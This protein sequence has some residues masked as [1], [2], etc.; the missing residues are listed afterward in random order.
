VATKDAK[1]TWKVS[2]V[3]RLSHV[4]ARTLHHYDAIG[5]LVP[6]QR[7][8]SGYRLYS[9]SDLQRLQQ[10]LLFRELGFTLD[11]IQQ[12]LD[13][14]AF[15][16]RTA[17]R[18]QRDLLVERKR[19]TEAV[20]RAVEKTMESLERG[21]E[22]DTKKMFEGFEQFDHAKYEDEARERWG[23]TEEYKESMR[24]TKQY[25]KADW[26]KIKAEGEA[27][28][29]RLAELMTAGRKPDDTEVMDAAERHRRHIDQWFYPL[30]HQGHVGLGDLYISD[31]R[32][33]EYYEKRGPGL[34]A[35]AAAAIR[36][37]AARA[38]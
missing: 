3:A 1:R 36:A 34:A 17:L 23:H 24:R 27:V 13:G 2:E 26:A 20:I 22:M 15:D 33:T 19:K 31:P 14:P 35:F 37:N 18:A 10:I 25:S 5:L 6:G 16:R 9:A 30:S 8:A 21:K 4:T 7:T 38:K 28:T 32:F 29:Q 11:A 12:L